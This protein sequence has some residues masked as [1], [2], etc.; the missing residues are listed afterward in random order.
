VKGARCFHV[1]VLC[2]A[3]G[4]EFLAPLR[5]WLFPTWSELRKKEGVKSML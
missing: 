1:L 4:R 5:F 2:A 3:K